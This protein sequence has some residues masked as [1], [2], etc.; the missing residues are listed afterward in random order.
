MSLA[1]RQSQTADWPAAGHMVALVP[2][3]CGAPLVTRA[4]H[5][6]VLRTLYRVVLR[7]QNACMHARITRAQ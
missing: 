5:R 2:R 6:W 7:L 1:A 4:A 3:L